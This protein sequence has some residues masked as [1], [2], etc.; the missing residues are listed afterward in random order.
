MEL[1]KKFFKDDEKVIGLCTLRKRDVKIY[2]FTPVFTSKQL[3]C[4]TSYAK[5]I[6]LS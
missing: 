3:A 2:S 4:G 1:L 5:N 6:F